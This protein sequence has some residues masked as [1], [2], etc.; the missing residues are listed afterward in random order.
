VI[1]AFDRACLRLPIAVQTSQAGPSSPSQTRHRIGPKG[2]RK[3]GGIIIIACDVNPFDMNLPES[4]ETP[5]DPGHAGQDVVGLVFD[6]VAS[7]GPDRWRGGRGTAEKQRTPHRTFI[8]NPYTV[9]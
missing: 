2:T 9:D 3:K 7:P 8:I 5:D 4:S 6:T 1:Q